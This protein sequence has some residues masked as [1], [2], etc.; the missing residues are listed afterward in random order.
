MGGSYAEQ[1]RKC[2]HAAV[3]MAR[4]LGGKSSHFI[5]RLAVAKG[6]DCRLHF[7]VEI[8]SKAAVKS[9]AELIAILFKQNPG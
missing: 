7:S 1:L 8:S 5:R 3:A 6:C 9:N 4:S 2:A